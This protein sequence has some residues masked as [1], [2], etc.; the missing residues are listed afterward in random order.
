MTKLVDMFDNATLYK[1]FQLAVIPKKSLKFIKEEIIS[2]AGAKKVLDFGCG[3]GYHAEYFEDT[4]YLGIEPLEKCV[5]KANEQFAK[6]RVRFK[7]GDHNTLKEIDD[8]TFDLVIAI[9]VL[10]HIEDET[11]DLFLG[12]AKRLLKPG[13]RLTTF[14]PVFHPD[15]SFSSK[16]VVSQDRGRNV[17]SV[18]GYLVHAK[19]HFEN[20]FNFSIQTK[21]LRIPYDHIVINY[22]KE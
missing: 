12:E 1:L 20:N 16:W 6:T 21:L 19:K 9:G 17:R 13:G 11:L 15:Q 4:D 2:P 7:V 10:H 3:V 18:E 14:D 22:M 8:E 5:K